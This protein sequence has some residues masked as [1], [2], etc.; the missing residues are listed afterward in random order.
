MRKPQKGNP[1]GSV[2]KG[3]GKVRGLSIGLYVVAGL[4]LLY[5]FWTAKQSTSYVATMMASGQ[6][7][8]RGN[9]YDIVRFYVSNSA[10]YAFFA[11]VLFTLGWMVQTGPFGASHPG[12]SRHPAPSARNR[13]KARDSQEPRDGEETRAGKDA[14]STEDDE[15]DFEDWFEQQEK[16]PAL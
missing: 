7:S 2:A 3:R 1:N 10:Q 14:S 5:T 12:P 4:L 15:D 11:I 6:L 9:E 8:F 16:E 13:D